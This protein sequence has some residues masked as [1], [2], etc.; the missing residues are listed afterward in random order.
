MAEREWFLAVDGQQVGPLT[1][2][3]VVCRIQ[4]GSVAPTTLVFTAG[5]SGWKAAR[6]TSELLARLGRPAPPVPPIPRAAPEVD[7]RILG[8]EMQFAEVVLDP[9]GGVV[10]E[11][12]VLMYMTEGVQME[13]ILGDGSGQRSLVDA[14]LGAGRRLLTGE[15]LFMTAFTNRGRARERVAFAAPCAGKILPMDLRELGGELLCQKDSFLFAVRGVSIQL[16]L[17]RRL[18]VGVL[19]GEGFVNFA[20]EIVHSFLPCNSSLSS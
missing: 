4:S 20:I 10:A 12:G 8:G 2:E 16:A 11:A 3:D 9:G 5:M 13:T 7:Y 1:E 19:G 18:G 17:Q 15:T 14:L 6:E